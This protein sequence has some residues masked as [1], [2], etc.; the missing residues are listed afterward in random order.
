MPHRSRETNPGGYDPTRHNGREAFRAA[1]H[2][3]YADQV[4][5]RMRA[6]APPRERAWVRYGVIKQRPGTVAKHLCHSRIQTEPLPKYSLVIPLP[7]P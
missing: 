5:G 2:A 7:T 6:H 1:S 4:H 3:G